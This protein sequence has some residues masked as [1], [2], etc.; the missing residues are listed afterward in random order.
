MNANAS[1]AI[2]F[3][4]KAAD[5]VTS[6]DYAAEIEWQRSQ[7]I[8]AFDESTLLRES[9]WVI[10][11]GGFREETVRRIFDYISLCFCDWESAEAIVHSSERCL[12]AAYSGFRNTRKLEA[13]VEISN[14]LVETGFGPLKER[15][16]ADPVNELRRLPHIGPI[17]SVHLAKNLGLQI[18]KPDRHLLRVS[19]SLGFGDDVGKLCSTIAQHTGEKVSVVDLILWRFVADVTP[20]VAI[21]WGVIL[22]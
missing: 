22:G 6:A 19:R 13:I 16:L 8:N 1:N 10:L 14:I 18:A 4:A 17:T 3:F 20:K 12:K 9:A 7:C 21:T 11:C 5:Y 2:L 15:I